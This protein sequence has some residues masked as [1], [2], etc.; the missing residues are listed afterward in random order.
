[1][2]IG[3]SG[4]AQSGKSTVAKIMADDFGYEQVAFADGIRRA[5]FALN[6]VIPNGKTGG[7]DRLQDLVT[8][9]GWEYTKVNNYEV[10]RLL[11]V[12]GTEVGR[13]LF[14][15]DIWV[16]ELFKVI[17]QSGS[18]NYVISDVRFPNEVGAVR[19]AGGIVWRVVR[20]FTGKV[21]EHVSETALDDLSFEKI[22]L[23]N[24]GINGLRKQVAAFL[25][26]LSDKK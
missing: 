11:Q 15:E 24:S 22:V 16:Q 6:P 17:G 14:D 21:N 1:M 3:L 18:G 8:K 4:Y 5:V 13:E 25:E 2:I 12:F 7:W 19:A 23:N 9:H 20:P 10:R 26:E